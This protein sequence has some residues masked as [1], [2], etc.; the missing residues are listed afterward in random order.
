M[1]TKEEVLELLDGVTNHLHF[2]RDKDQTSV[3]TMFM[4]KLKKLRKG[5]EHLISR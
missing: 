1:S 4:F 2:G 5:K 3:H